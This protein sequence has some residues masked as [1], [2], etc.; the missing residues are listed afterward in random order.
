MHSVV[1]VGRERRPATAQ[2]GTNW[3]RG[4]RSRWTGTGWPR[5]G[6]E[7]SRYTGVRRCQGHTSVAAR[8]RQPSSGY[9]R[10]AGRRAV[11]R[12][13]FYLGLRALLELGWS[14]GRCDFFLSWHGS[15][16]TKKVPCLQEAQHLTHLLCNRYDG[17][18][19]LGG[20]FIRERGPTMWDET[21]GV[22]GTG[23]STGIGD[24]YVTG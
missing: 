13:P 8:L 12:A 4:R 14:L 7:V 10:A 3:A 16:S 23:W 6:S 20:A 17:D 21:R 11:R 24:A 15:F 2:S 18:A 5:A 22:C 19:C 9:S 1:A